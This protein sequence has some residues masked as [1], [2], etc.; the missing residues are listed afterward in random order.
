MKDSQGNEITVGTNVVVMR[1]SVVGESPNYKVVRHII[2]DFIVAE[3]DGYDM[4]KE[5]DGKLVKVDWDGLALAYIKGVSDSDELFYETKKR[6]IHKKI[7]CKLCGNPMCLTSFMPRDYFIRVMCMKPNPS[8]FEEM[9]LE[10]CENCGATI[11]D[12]RK[13]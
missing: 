6:T 5:V 1:V 13:S 11:Q 3:I 9:I 10:D 7:P 2:D 4:K 12:Q 8:D